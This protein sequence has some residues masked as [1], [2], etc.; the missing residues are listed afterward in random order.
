MDG[1][2]LKNFIN[3]KIQLRKKDDFL[4]HGYIKEIYSDSILFLTDGR[5]RVID[6]AEIAEI[7]EAGPMMPPPP[8]NKCYDYND[9]SNGTRP[10]DWH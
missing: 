1:N 6:F 4:L 3:K 9:K 5:L 2:A 8:D 10:E 7:R